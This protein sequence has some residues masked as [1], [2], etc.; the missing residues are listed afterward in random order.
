MDKHAAIKFLEERGYSKIVCMGDNACADAAV[1]YPN[2]IGLTIIA[3]S[4]S[5]DRDYSILM[6]PKLFI[7]EEGDPYELKNRMETE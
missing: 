1:Q 5:L 6:M 7:L 2:L 3:S 4:P